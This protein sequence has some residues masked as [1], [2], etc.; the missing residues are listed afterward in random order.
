MSV[1][2]MNRPDR[3]GSNIIGHI[4]QIILAKNN[5]YYIEKIEN[6]RENPSGSDLNNSIFIKIL[7]ELI[8]YLNKNKKRGDGQYISIVDK[9]DEYYKLHNMFCMRKLNIN[10][11]LKIKQDILSYFKE[12]Y[13]NIISNKIDFFAKN[14]GYNIDYD[15]KKTICLHLRLDD[16]YYNSNGRGNNS[17]FEYN[18]TY[19]SQYYINKINSDNNITNEKEKIDFLKSVIP[20]QEQ[21]IHPN[22]TNYDTQTIMN[23]NL[24]K[25]IINKIKKNNPE[26][27][28]LIIASPNG[29]IEIDCD[30]LIRTNDPNYDLFCMINSDIL[31]CSKSNFSLT[32]AF[33][34][35]GSQIYIP[36]WGH[37][38]SMGFQ[39]KYDKNKN[40]QY[41]Y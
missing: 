8:N 6:T 38:A 36:M 20:I 17:R 18:G 31:I 23:N 13:L 1:I 30:Y 5:D 33:F 35:K 15:W 4:C 27:K 7:N 19:S 16:I 25:N 12:R 10:T 9:N 39:S 24:L 22:I 28:I 3:L 11:C 41:V 32:A 29:K 34:H 14:K 2:I 37:F 21:K 40:I 26:H